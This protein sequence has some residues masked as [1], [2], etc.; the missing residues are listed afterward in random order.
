[1]YIVC[2]NKEWEL[3]MNIPS[4]HCCHQRKAA[5]SDWIARVN[6]VSYM[7]LQITRHNAHKEW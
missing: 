4:V 7:L 2:E 1:M 6:T 3:L 5:T